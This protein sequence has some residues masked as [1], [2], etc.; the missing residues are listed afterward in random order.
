MDL[1]QG[2]RKVASHARAYRPLDVRVTDPAHRPPRSAGSVPIQPAPEEI[3]MLQIEPR[4]GGYLGGLKQQVGQRRAPLRRL[5]SM[6][7]EYPRAA[8]LAALGVAEQYRL[9]DLDRLE[10]M[11]LKRIAEE[12]FVVPFEPTAPEGGDDE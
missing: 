2:P 1:Y 10:R 5:L 11:V 4:I 3:Q 7:Q 9:F 8:F 12:Y 6:L